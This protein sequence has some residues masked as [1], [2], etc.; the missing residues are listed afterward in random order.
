[1]AFENRHYVI[2]PALEIN[3]INFE[4]VLETSASTCRYS[5]D[6]TQ[7]FVKYEGE[8]P[9]SVVAIV[10]KSAEYTHEQILEILNTREWSL[11]SEIY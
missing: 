8:Q 6:S 3:N 4:Q 1:M 7:T 2:I 5:V 10:N 9:P 11:P